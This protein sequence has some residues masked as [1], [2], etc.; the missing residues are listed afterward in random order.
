[1]L[2]NTRVRTATIVATKP[3]PGSK[4]VV[5][6]RLK[7]DIFRKRIGD[8][9]IS[10]LR[11]RMHDI[12]VVIDMLSGV[13]TNLNK[14]TIVRPY[15]PSFLWLLK[16]W[17]GTVL[18]YVWPSVL[19]M[20]VMTALF[21]FIM[22]L[23][24][25]EMS[26]DVEYSLFEDLE[27]IYSGWKSTAGLVT[28]VSTFFLGEAFRYWRS[29]YGTARQLQGCLAN[30]SLILVTYATRNQ[31]DGKLTDGAVTALDD[32]ARIQTLTHQ[33][34]WCTVV[35]RFRCLL[36]PEGYSYLLSKKLITQGEYASLIELGEN[37]L[38]GHFAG[39]TWLASRVVIADKR[40]EINLASGATMH[41]FCNIITKLRGKMGTISDLHA[42][43]MPLA[44]VHF[45]HLLISIYLLFTPIAL[46]PTYGYWSVPYVGVLTLFYHGL[47]KLSLCLLDPMDND[48]YHETSS[49]QTAGFDV[50][51]LIREAQTGGDRFKGCAV[52]LPQ[53]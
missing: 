28:F 34:F 15:R 16:Q 4:T 45:V 46:L 20:M 30:I 10:R 14:G 42:G 41:A 40:G 36:S 19:T 3:P 37:S 13:D 22:G 23:V 18:Q 8:E 1:M 11:Q 47:F 6:Y 21:C 2:Y 9:E 50:G 26:L 27:K 7:H 53:Y 12:Q 25:G 32:V 33:L 24:C 35:E 39:I 29:F 43:R 52:A 17:K 44:Y 49:N 48:K 5:L 31:S 38:G 51:V